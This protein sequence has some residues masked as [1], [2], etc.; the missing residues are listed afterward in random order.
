MAKPKAN[1]SFLFSCVV[2]LLD[3][4]V[5]SEVELPFPTFALLVGSPP[6][7]FEP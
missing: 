7:G 4:D 6:L 2:T 1:N 5:E 3:L